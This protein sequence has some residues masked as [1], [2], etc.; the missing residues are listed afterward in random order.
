MKTNSA[1]SSYSKVSF[2][3]EVMGASPHRLIA[4]LFEGA[5]K[6]IANA[7]R[8]IQGGQFAAK[9]TAIGRAISIIG[10]GL[11]G[12]L[13]MEAGGDL[14]VKLRQ[15]YEYMIIQLGRANLHNDVA[16]LDEVARLLGEIKEGWDGI[17]PAGG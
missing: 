16:K 17:R 10:D 1:I 7:K 9:G 2:E 13:N 3:S 4:M 14:A 11:N 5:L 15:L 12:S 6:D 8:A